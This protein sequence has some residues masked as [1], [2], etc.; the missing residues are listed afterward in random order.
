MD[1]Y[2]I[3]LEQTQRRQSCILN[4]PSIGREDF[5]LL[6]QTNYTDNAMDHL[7]IFNK[8]GTHNHIPSHDS[9]KR[10][11]KINNINNNRS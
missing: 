11:Q 3:D 2:I 8:N 4:V 7:H 5:E 10:V 9:L 6:F 1:I